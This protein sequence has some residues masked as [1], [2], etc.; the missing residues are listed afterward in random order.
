MKKLININTIEH[1]PLLLRKR[2]SKYE[3]KPLVLLKYVSDYLI[4]AW[5]Y[6]NRCI[7]FEALNFYSKSILLSVAL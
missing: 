4:L 6:L 7:T 2:K 3:K 1:K 5:L